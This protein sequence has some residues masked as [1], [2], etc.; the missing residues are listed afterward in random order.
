VEDG[1]TPAPSKASSKGGRTL[2]W[3]LSLI[4][5]S[6][7]LEL[8]G[9]CSPV[10]PKPPRSPWGCGKAWEGLQ[11]AVDPGGLDRLLPTWGL[12]SLFM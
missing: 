8:V 10:N 5:N 9:T 3:D 12:G 2:T 7:A 4:S 1:Q 11:A 6:F